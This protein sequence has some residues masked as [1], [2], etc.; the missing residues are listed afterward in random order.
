MS[1]RFLVPLAIVA[2]ALALRFTALDFGLPLAESRPDELT[3][4]FQ[5]MKFGRG[6]LNPHSFNYPTLWKY[7]QF[8][9]FGGWFAAGKLT[10]EIPNQDAFLRDFFLAETPYRWV[11]RALSALAGVVTVTMLLRTPGTLGGTDGASSTGRWAALFL[12]VCALHVRESRFGTTD[13]PVTMFVTAALLAAF[14][15]VREGGWRWAAVAGAFAGLAASTKYPG[16]LACVPVGVAALLAPVVSETPHAAPWNVRLRW[17]AAAAAA[18]V[19]AFLLGS[20]YVALDFGQFVKDLRF[21]AAHLAA[22]HHVS[23]GSGWWYHLRVSLGEGMGWGLLAAGL[24]G[25]VVAARRS[26]EG[27]VLASFVLGYWLFI[28]RGNTAFFRY[29]LP[30]VPA[31]CMGAGVLVASLPRASWRVALALGALVPTVVPMLQLTRLLRAEDTRSEMGAWIEANVP[32]NAEILHA[33]APAGCPLLQRDVAN[34]TREFE[35]RQGRADSAGFRK[36]DDPRWYD[37]TRPAY[38]VWYLQRPA[39][40]FS[41]MAADAGFDYASTRTIADALAT[42]PAWILVESSPLAAYSTVDP[43]VLAMVQGPAYRAVHVARG[44]D[45][46]RAAASR[47]DVQDAFYAPLVGFDG[48]DAPGPNLVLYRR[49]E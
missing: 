2:L 34:Q 41:K 22:G 11:Q 26:R 13:A 20:P 28:G 19:V 1:R 42:K 24:A 4:G 5:A 44:H 30:V 18:S 48:W 3:L 38:D 32:A 6:D 14:A 31:L 49:V 33:G 7:V 16:A 37:T 29:M 47:M 46:A 39:T 15:L 25:V 8:G 43:A 27:V 45:S 17:T 9:G 12:A 35:A 40:A 10:G 21:E 36:P 23:V